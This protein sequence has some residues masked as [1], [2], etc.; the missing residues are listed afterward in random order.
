MRVRVGVIAVV[1]ALGVHGL[2]A[3]GLAHLSR[4]GPVLSSLMFAPPKAS[5]SRVVTPP[6]EPPAPQPSAAKPA[7]P[8]PRKLAQRPRATEKKPIRHVEHAAPQP[9]PEPPAPPPVFDLD[10]ETATTVEGAR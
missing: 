8:Q 2:L 1:G 10:P 3:I 6:T 5:P 9:A 7:L 4:R